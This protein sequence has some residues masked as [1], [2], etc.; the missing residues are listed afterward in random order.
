L[1]IVFIDNKEP[2]AEYNYNHLCE[3]L[4]N[5]CSNKIIRSSGV[6]GR[7]AAYQAAAESSTTPWFFAVF[8]KLRVNPEFDWSWQPDRLQEPKHYIFHARN[9]INGLTYG[10][11]ALIAYNKNLVLNNPGVGLDFTLDSAHE[12]VPLLSGTA[13]Y[14][15][16]PWSAWRTAFRECIK[17]KNSPDVE[18]QYRLDKWLTVAQGMPNGQYSIWGAEDAVE[19]YTAV[20]GDFAEL[21]KSYDWSWLASYALIKR[22]LTLNQ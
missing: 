22:N 1:D 19:Y 17:L 13:E 12:V 2:T 11:Q 9:P 7:V 3:T 10:H 5:K 4:A 15:D 18:S 14:A 8:A 20:N 21:R 6:T 16:T